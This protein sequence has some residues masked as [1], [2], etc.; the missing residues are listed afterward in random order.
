MRTKGNAQREGESRSQVL[1]AVASSQPKNPSM[2]G[3]Y[4]DPPEPLA[5]EEMLNSL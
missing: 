3:R 5:R 4:Y 1:R 2:P